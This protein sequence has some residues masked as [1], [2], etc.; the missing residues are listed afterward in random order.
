MKKDTET[1]LLDLRDIFDTLFGYT[2][3]VLSFLLIIHICSE[4]TLVRSG[5]KGIEQSTEELVKGSLGSTEGPQ[6][7]VK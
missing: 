6:K 7:S 4:Y 1:I 5:G 2:L 3:L